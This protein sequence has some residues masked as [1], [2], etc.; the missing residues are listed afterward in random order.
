MEDSVGLTIDNVDF[1]KNASVKS[2]QIGHNKF[3]LQLIEANGTIDDLN[4]KLEEKNKELELFKNNLRAFHLQIQEKNTE[5]AQLKEKLN[6]TSNLLDVVTTQMNT[7]SIS[8]DQDQTKHQEDYLLLLSERNTLQNNILQLNKNNSESMDKYNELKVKYQTTLELLE[9]KSKD[10]T[11]LNTLQYNTLNELNL[12]KDLNSKKQSEIDTVKQEL[13]S[14]NNENSVL[15]TRIFD[16]EDYSKDLTRQYSDYI[17]SKKQIK[18]NKEPVNE[19]VN[20]TGNENV[21]ENVNPS[22]SVRVTRRGMKISRR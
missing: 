9:N 3:Q 14:L 22:A 7:I 6:S 11:D 19:T 13:Y 10:I 17:S 2:K 15:K 1:V 8:S 18:S 4:V 16:L 12:Y 20:E 21:N 5:I